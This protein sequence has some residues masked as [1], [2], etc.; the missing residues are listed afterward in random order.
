MMNL[1][2]WNTS[3]VWRIQRAAPE[4]NT[5][6]AETPPDGFATPPG[7]TRYGAQNILVAGGCGVF[8]E[9]PENQRGHGS[10]MPTL[11]S[12]QILRPDGFHILKYNRLTPAVI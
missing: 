7:Q 1:N 10:F 6:S 5:F 12:R 4:N 11:K 2:G 8:K 3:T 9:N